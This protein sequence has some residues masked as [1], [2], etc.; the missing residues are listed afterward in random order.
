MR[1]VLRAACCLFIV[2]FQYAFSSDGTLSSGTQGM[3][4]SQFPL[5]VGCRWTYAVY[6]SIK[7]SADT[8]NVKIVGTTQLSDG[9]RATVWQYTY[10][11]SVDT[12]FVARSRDTVFFYQSHDVGS[13]SKI[14]IF[15]L[16]V[17]RRWT[18]YPPGS[19]TVS[20]AER[21]TAPARRFRN[22]YR[23]AEHPSI[24]NFYGGTTYWFVANVGMVRMH[25]KWV[26][27]MADDRANV[28][29]ELL[30]FKIVR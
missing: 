28:I 7:K 19:M 24:G 1:P 8:V 16:T 20:A 30:R 6:D 22:S 9:N 18:T 21:V 29:W 14:L 15:P 13:L 3:K 2:S 11:K 27:T 12:Q 5:S 23:I 4:A 10:S 25:K 26:D 17:G